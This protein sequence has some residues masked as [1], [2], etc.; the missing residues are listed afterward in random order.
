M[1]RALSWLILAALAV[2]AVGAELDRASYERAELAPLVPRPFRSFAQPTLT[3]L[4]LITSDPA[5]A[6][7]EAQLLVRRRPM[8][9]EH[10]YMLALADQRAGDAK[11]AA[12]ASLL[13]TERGWRARPVQI[14]AARS[15]LAKGQV[16]A[17]ANRVAALWA[18][19]PGDPVVPELTGAL[20]AQRQG[21]EA[22]AARMAATRVWQNAAL[23]S[24][25][26]MTSAEVA[27]HTISLALADGAHFQCGLLT[28][29][30][31]QFVR[32]GQSEVGEDGTCEP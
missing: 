24:L 12:A 31:A 14:A 5:V 27:R 19:Q 25:G 7:N 6:K 23:T 4:A 11:D 15:A 8:P 32:M 17:A 1:I 28:A 30:N 22:F 29:A 3:M 21:P 20:L 9:A 16:E 13:A 10:L 26:S 2:V 18:L